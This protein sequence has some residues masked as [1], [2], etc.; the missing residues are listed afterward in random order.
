MYFILRN[1][2]KSTLRYSKKTLRTTLLIN[3]HRNPNITYFYDYQT[4]DD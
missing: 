2:I 3:I 4:A 1:K